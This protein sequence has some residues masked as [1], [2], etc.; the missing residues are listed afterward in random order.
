MPR[1]GSEAYVEGLPA[2]AV[3]GLLFTRAIHRRSVEVLLEISWTLP[4]SVTEDPHS[5][6]TF[7][8]S[9]VRIDFTTDCKLKTQLRPCFT[10][11]IKNIKNI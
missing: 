11:L 7:F 3:I 2:N 8:C 10:V 6:Y 4:I 9:L 5:G 1:R